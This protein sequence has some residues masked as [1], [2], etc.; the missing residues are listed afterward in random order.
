MKYNNK[1]CLNIDFQL[2]LSPETDPGVNSK[3]FCIITCAV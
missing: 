3:G 1:T 2:Y